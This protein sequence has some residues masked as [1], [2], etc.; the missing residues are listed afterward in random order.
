MSEQGVRTTMSISVQCS[1]CGK[2]LKA[3]DE[4]AGRRVKCPD[5]GQV[6]VVPTESPA[7]HQAS[8]TLPSSGVSSVGS[9]G[10]PVAASRPKQQGRQVRW[11]WYVGG[12]VV[13]VCVAMG[14][15]VLY[16][17]LTSGGGNGA[18]IVPPAMSRTEKVAEG[19]GEEKR[20]DDKKTSTKTT[21]GPLRFVGLY[22]SKASDYE[23]YLRFYEDGT[24][25]C[26]SSPSSPEHVAV[27]FNNECAAAGVGRG[28]YSV[29]GVHINFSETTD[30][31][32]IDYSGTIK[33]YIPH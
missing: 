13:A 3:K 20:P 24:V 32:E 12:G 31:G 21:S 8:F 15:L 11:P 30:S 7:S 9:R 10:K 28:I 25:M 26:V 5:C 17:T 18:V 33:P 29:N 27:W 16:H 19:M 2:S 22:H 4:L 23:K 14:S 6:V 1:G